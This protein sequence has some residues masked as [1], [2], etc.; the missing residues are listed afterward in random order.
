MVMAAGTG[1]HIFPALA[2]AE[3]L[4]AGESGLLALDW[5]NGNRTILV[6][7]RLTG[8]LVGQT[9]HTS[10]P[11]IYRALIEATAFG[12][13][14]GFGSMA[15][16]GVRRSF[17]LRVGDLLASGPYSFSRNPQIVGGTLM[18]TG[19]A[20]LWPSWYALGWAVLWPVMFHPMVLTE[21]EHMQRIFGEGYRRYSEQVARYI[22]RGRASPR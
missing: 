3:K 8:L 1:G 12:A 22:G 13:L 15:W 20:W 9:L 7:P 17:G 6:D 14:I 4:R 19:V 18:I 10:A 16:L 21:E 11:E 5:N 2:V